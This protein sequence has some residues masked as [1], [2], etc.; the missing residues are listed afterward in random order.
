MFNNAVVTI[1]LVSAVATLISLLIDKAGYGT[2]KY[3]AAYVFF[4]AIL[5]SFYT[6]DSTESETKNQALQAKIELITSIEYKAGQVLKNTARVTDGE[7]RGFVFA[8]LA[9]LERNKDSVPDSYALARQFAIGSNVLEN[10]QDDGPQRLYQT[11]RLNDA[12]DAMES[13][14]TG[15]SSG[16]AY[17]KGATTF[18]P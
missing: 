8:T 14:L 17:Q 13:L 2:R 9:F 3:H 7:K 11:W 6:Y 15:L 5:A 4:V 12:A 10:K 16:N 18:N 1:G